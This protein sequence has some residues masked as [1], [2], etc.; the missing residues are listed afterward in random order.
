MPWGKICRSPPRLKIE[1]CRLMSEYPW[2][3]LTPF[4]DEPLIFRRTARF[5]SVGK[6]AVK[7]PPR[8]TS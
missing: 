3:R 2:A 4:S 7:L 1:C 8:P 5:R 6:L